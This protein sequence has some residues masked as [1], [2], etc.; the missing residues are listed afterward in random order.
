[1]TNEII[2]QDQ[3]LEVIISDSITIDRAFAR[4]DMM[5]HITDHIAQK[6]KRG[7]DFGKHPGW[8]KDE[9]LLPGAEKVMALLGLRPSYEQTGA[10]EEWDAPPFFCLLYT[11]PSPRD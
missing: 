9:L 11:S 6:F 3:P 2:I 7:I 10:I 5:R 1:M 4:A 8:Q